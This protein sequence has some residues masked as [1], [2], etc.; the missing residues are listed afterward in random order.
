MKKG[1]GGGIGLFEY[2]LISGL[3]F[4]LYFALM[5]L[6][7]N[8]IFGVM[9]IVNLAHGDVVMAGAFFAYWTYAHWHLSPLAVIGLVLVLFVIV[10]FFLYFPLVPRL[11]DSMDPEMLSL[12]LFFGVSQVLEALAVIVFGNNPRTVNFPIANAAPV[13]LL[14]QTYQASWIFSAGLSVGVIGLVY[15]YLFRTRLGYVT[16]AVM[17]NREEAAVSGIPV[18]RVSAL[19]FGLGLATAAIAGVLSPLMLGAVDP[20]MGGELTAA[21]FAVVI[22]GSLGN[23]IGTLI[24]GLL[25]GVTLM[26]MQTYFSSW[27]NMVPYVALLAV[28]L[29]RPGGLL[30]RGVRHA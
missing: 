3:L 11:M 1:R 21:A 29:V 8:L 23:P 13:H 17:D 6:G 25:Y 19:V 15:V 4:G 7:L 24:G 28:L 30:G 14:G 2:A 26:I 10:G 27:A 16:R 20:A 5:S 12:I 18:G 22:I 9:R